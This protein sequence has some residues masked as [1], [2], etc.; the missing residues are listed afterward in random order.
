MD[1][2]G[3]V[4]EILMVEMSS[5]DV[6]TLLRTLAP[7]FVSMADGVSKVVGGRDQTSL[8]AEIVS[9]VLRHHIAVHV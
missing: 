9:A 4:F 5:D 2:L 1:D 3:S 6:D 7:M 8:R